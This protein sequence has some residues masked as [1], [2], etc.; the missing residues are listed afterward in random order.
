MSDAELIL[1]GGD[2]LG[3]GIA[4]AM[5]ADRPRVPGLVLFLGLGMLIGEE[6]SAASTSTTPS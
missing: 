3:A 4:A 1:V 6:G 2:L 5:V